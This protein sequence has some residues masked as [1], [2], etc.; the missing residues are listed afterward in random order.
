MP[1]HNFLAYNIR[2]YFNKQPGH[3]LGCAQ[4]GAA[5]HVRNLAPSACVKRDLDCAGLM[6]VHHYSRL[7]TCPDCGWWY[8]REFWV[9]YELND[10]CLDFLIVGQPSKKGA[11]GEPWQRAM[12]NDQLYHKTAKLP[13]ALGRLFPVE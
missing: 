3:L 12:T 13:K 2:S 8:V 6:P 9:L 7:F 5:L 4:C 11:D 10:G 1:F